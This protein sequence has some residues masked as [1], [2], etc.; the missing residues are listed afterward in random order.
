[1]L[2]GY[3]E[4]GVDRVTFLLETLPESAALTELDVLARLAFGA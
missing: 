1:M 3:A 2:E 4:A